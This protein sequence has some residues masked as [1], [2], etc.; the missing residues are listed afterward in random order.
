MIF[1]HLEKLTRRGWWTVCSQPAV[2]GAPSTDEVL[3]WGP[4]DGYVYQKCFVEFFAEREDVDKLEQKVAEAGNGWVHYFA[5]NVQVRKHRPCGQGLQGLSYLQGECR[6]NVSEDG[7]NAVTWGVFPGQEV[8]QTTIIEKESF[9]TWK[10]CRQPILSNSILTPKC[11][12]TKRSLSGQN[13]HRSTHPIH[14]SASSWRESGIGDGLSALF[15]MT[16]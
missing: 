6:T 15:I 11:R 1:P 12:R 9:I 16:T 14:Q 5:G 2:N 10:V 4:G 3:G 8:V 13:G 7:R